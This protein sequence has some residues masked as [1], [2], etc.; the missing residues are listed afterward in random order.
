MCLRA[1]G[2]KI[3]AVNRGRRPQWHA[4]AEIRQIGVEV[5]SIGPG[6]SSE[7]ASADKGV[8][9]QHCDRVYAFNSEKA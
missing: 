4:V 8:K 6:V 1:S 2:E 5:Q 3:H 7:E 9:S